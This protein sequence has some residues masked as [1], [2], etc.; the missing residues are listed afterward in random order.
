MKNSSF[1][2]TEEPILYNIIIEKCLDIL[3]IDV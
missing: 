1:S 2:F 3:E